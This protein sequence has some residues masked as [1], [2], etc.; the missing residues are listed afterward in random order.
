VRA[1]NWKQ[2]A[3]SILASVEYRRLLGGTVIWWHCFYMEQ[4]V[5][6]WL[7]FDLSNSARTVA[8][9]SFCRT[10]PLLLVSLFSGPIIDY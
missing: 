4:V 3:F 9:V 5:L 10:L 6:G 2:G 1:A 7:V 8:L